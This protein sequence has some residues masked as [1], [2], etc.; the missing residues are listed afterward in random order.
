MSLPSGEIVRNVVEGNGGNG[1][2]Q[3][4]RSGQIVVDLSTSPVDLTPAIAGKMHARC[5]L[6]ADAPLLR[7]R[8]AADAGTLAVPLGAADSV[9]HDIQ[10]FLSLFECDF[11]HVGGTV[12]GHARKSE[13]KG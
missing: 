6:F 1:L 13:L 12:R 8:A 5:I 9:L 10:P 2:L 4:C 11:N 3:L 7:P